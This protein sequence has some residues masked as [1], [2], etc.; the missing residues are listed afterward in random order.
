M[1]TWGSQ[2]GCHSMLCDSGTCLPSLSCLPTWKAYNWCAFL[3]PLPSRLTSW[4]GCSE[5]P[6]ASCHTLAT[7]HCPKD[8]SKWQR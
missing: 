7:T 8:R 2:L 1:V 5:T 4:L 6:R 3:H